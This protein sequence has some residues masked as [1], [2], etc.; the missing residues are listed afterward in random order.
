MSSTLGAPLGGTMRGGHQGFE[1]T[2][3]GLITPPN[4]SAG[5]GSLLEFGNSVALGEPGT[6]FTC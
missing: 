6:P 3:L 5:G 4:F 2:A 1:S